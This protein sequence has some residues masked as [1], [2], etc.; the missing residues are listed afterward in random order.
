MTPATHDP[1]RLVV[2]TSV[3]TNPYTGRQFGEGVPG[4]VAAFTALL[5]RAGDAVRCH[6]PPSI[7]EEVKTF[8]D[9]DEL[10]DDFE[11]VVALQSPDRYGVS[12]PGYL[13]YELIHDIRTR[14]DQG[15][16]VAEK[17]VRTSHPEGEE[18]T[19][20][21]LRGE[22]RD[23]LRAGFLDSREDVDLILLARELDA[24]LVSSD[25]AVVRW[26][27]NLGIRLVRPEGLRRL[28]EGLL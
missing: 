16:R 15:L 5:R 27:E 10:P 8:L 2:D 23:A 25:H 6:M 20:R 1:L 26:A 13:L 17:A 21:R 14:I 3:L 11:A 19:I 12:V 28:L 4:A 7:F 9:E 24:A 22:Y 18:A